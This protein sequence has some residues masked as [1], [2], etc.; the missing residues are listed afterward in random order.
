M[1]FLIVSDTHGRADR[2]AEVL[3]R[4]RADGLLFLGDG[5]RDLS[6][7]PDAFT[8]RTVRGNCD[9]FGLNEHPEERLEV[10]GATRILMMHGHRYG[11]K[12][13]LGAALVAA[14]AREADV[15]LYGHTHRPEITHF[16]AG[17]VVGGEILQKPLIVLNPGS[18]GQPPDGKPTFG[19]LTV[20][21][22]GILPS[23]GEY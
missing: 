3:A 11:V 9:F 21:A 22:N 5:L 2:L 14:V 18:L 12:S 19:T 15:L 20:R 10:F 17:D 1:D 23:I 13:G 16:A 7:V 8:L 4:S 6:V